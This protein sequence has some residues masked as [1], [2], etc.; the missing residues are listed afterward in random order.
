MKLQFNPKRL[1]TKHLAAVTL[2]LNLGAAGLYAQQKSV[3]MTFSGT[4]ENT[5]FNLKA[6]AGSAEDDFAGDGTLGSFTF[7]DLNAELVSASAPASCSGPNKLYAVRA[8]TT[9]V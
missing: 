6:G 9:G 4:S 5:T 1:A 2:L 8:V 7:R 3:S